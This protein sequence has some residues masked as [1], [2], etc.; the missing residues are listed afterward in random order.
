MTKQ[1]D[2]PL[3]L[4]EF[5]RSE[6]AVDFA[7]PPAD[8]MTLDAL[9]GLEGVHDDLALALSTT[10]S[11]LAGRP[12]DVD[13]AFVDQVYHGCYCDYLQKRSGAGPV[14]SF[15][16]PPFEGRAVLE[17]R[18]PLMAALADPRAEEEDGVTVVLNGILH[19]LQTAMAA[20]QPVV[21]S[22]LV[23]EPDASAVRIAAAD[24]LVE[25]VA[26]QVDRPEWWMTFC[27]PMAM[28][29]PL[30]TKLESSPRPL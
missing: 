9:R 21:V 5:A 27:Y 6:S 7:W 22:N 23:L 16:L 18:D 26:I 10:L 4:R 8:P 20:I 30:S 28:L 12:V 29:K 25:V 11:S 2:Y 14:C 19:D 15:A 3:A 24:D 13:T 17:V 1:Q